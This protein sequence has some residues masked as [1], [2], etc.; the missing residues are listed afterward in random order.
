MAKLYSFKYRFEN[1][2]IKPLND[3]LW[4]KSHQELLLRIVNSPQGRDMLC[5]DKDF[6]GMPI[7]G[8]AKNR[9]TGFLGFD[10]DKVRLVSDFRVGAKWANVI[11]YRWREFQALAREH[12]SDK[13]NGQTEILLDGGY[14]MAATT[15]TFYPDPDSEGDPTTMDGYVGR[16]DLAGQTLSDLIAGVGTEANTSFAGSFSPFLRANS[17]SNKYDYLRRRIYGFDTSSLGSD[18]I[19]SAIF[20]HYFFNETNDL[21]GEN[22]DNSKAVLSAVT[23]SSNIALQA[24]DY[25][26]FQGV[27]FGRGAKQVDL[28]LNAYAPITLNGDGIAGIN[29]AGVTNLGKRSGWDFDDTEVG[30]TWV[31]NLSQSINSRFADQAGTDNDP[32]LVV[33]HSAVGFQNLLLMG[34]G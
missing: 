16:Q 26:Q 17:I 30:L 33:V 21:L 29:N 22:S 9:V 3:D 8:F 25:G 4:F 27:D 19:N 31:I 5:I 32:K 7:V 6:D 23:P 12:Y 28:T 20:S 14:R 24:S 1:P 34:V 13:V 18:S 2:E 10:G 15:S 11:R